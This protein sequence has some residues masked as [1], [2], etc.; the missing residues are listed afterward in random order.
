[1]ADS[2]GLG[3]DNIAT[4]GLAISLTWAFK[5]V[6]P[7]IP[8]LMAFLATL[9]PPVLV[10]AG[11]IALIVAHVWKFD[12]LQIRDAFEEWRAGQDLPDDVPQGLYMRLTKLGLKSRRL[13]EALGEWVDGLSIPE[14]LALV[15]PAGAVCRDIVA[16]NPLRKLLDAF[17]EWRDGLV[18]PKELYFASIVGLAWLRF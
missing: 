10:A 9:S 1:M 14:E 2:I 4:I 12:V 15:T 3:L 8:A 6:Q 7:I 16:F 11:A 13:A 5:L 18:I 17:E